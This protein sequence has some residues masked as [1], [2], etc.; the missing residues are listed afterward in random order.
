MF[1][2]VVDVPEHARRSVDAFL[3]KGSPPAVVLEKIRE[4]LQSSEQVA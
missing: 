3:R 4:L 2:G 1:S